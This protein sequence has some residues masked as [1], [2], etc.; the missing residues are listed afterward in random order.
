MQRKNLLMRFDVSRWGLDPVKSRQRREGRWQVGSLIYRVFDGSDV[1]AR[2]RMW[3]WS[4][5]LGF[6]GGFLP[7]S[8]CFANW[9]LDWWRVCSNTVD[10]HRKL[11][12][13]HSSKENKKHLHTH[14]HDISQ[15]LNLRQLQP[16]QNGNYT[17]L[18]TNAAAPE[19]PFNKLHRGPGRF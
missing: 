18:L 3:L 14:I 10:K 11:E 7:N 9:E 2:D 16:A 12:P 8:C 4:R 6:N 5:F 15:H 19:S 17:T 1:R 13:T